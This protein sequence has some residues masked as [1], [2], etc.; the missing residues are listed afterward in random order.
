MTYE[1]ELY[2]SQKIDINI[3]TG[4]ASKA[5]LS[6]PSNLTDQVDLEVYSA[7]SNVPCFTLMH[8]TSPNTPIF[9]GYS[10]QANSNLLVGSTSGKKNVALL[11]SFLR[12]IA[13]AIGGAVYDPQLGMLVYPKQIRAAGPMLYP[14]DIISIFWKFP[15][16]ADQKLFVEI[17]AS[18]KR[19]H[20]SA[21]PV[22]YGK[23]NSSIFE[24]DDA[25]SLF[26]YFRTDGNFSWTG[27]SP[28]I[29]G[30]L[31]LATPIQKIEGKNKISTLELNFEA[32]SFL[33]DKQ[34]ASS[35]YSIFV[36]ISKLVSCR[37]GVVCVQRNRCYDRRGGLY[38]GNGDIISPGHKT[39]WQ[40]IANIK[41]WLSWFGDDVLDKI[42][43]QTLPREI[44]TEGH[45]L[46]IGDL[47]QD[48]RQL[49][50]TF[51]LLPVELLDPLSGDRNASSL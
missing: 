5:G 30:S 41:A 49:E 27:S 7:D 21:Y 24:L 29:C 38:T 43:E 11:V 6:I 48:Q 14:V 3:L 28:F 35:I 10:L 25:D 34:N 22:L 16:I 12:E 8:D 36:D 23:N 50:R 33:L 1:L 31:S 51:P 2:T 15:A 45:L 39:S 13:S 26:S 32:G 17:F 44:L 40:G 47:P 4:T 18:L 37:H 42:P 20:P 46:K 9:D 19:G